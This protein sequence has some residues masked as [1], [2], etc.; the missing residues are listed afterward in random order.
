MHDPSASQ[1]GPHS[2][3]SEP[4]PLQN[5]EVEKLAH[6]LL[7][8]A[9]R[10]ERRYTLAIAG[11]PGSGKSTL[12]QSLVECVNARKGDGFAVVVAMDGFHLANAVLDSLGLRGVKGSPPT[13]DAAGLCDLLQTLRELPRRSTWI[14]V[15]C[16]RLHEPVAEGVE[17]GASCRLVVAEGQYLL[18]DRPPWSELADYFDAAW[19]LDIDR[20]TSLAGV[21]ERHMRGGNGPEQARRR[22]DEN[23]RPNAL[24]I[25]PTR[26]RAQ[27]VI[28]ARV[29]RGQNQ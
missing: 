3:P 1:P 15:Y 23:D 5:S 13:Y 22:I 28:D 7:C 17:A 21:A 18:L 29:L 4:Q 2:V 25:E 6:E 9:E 16:R 10:S 12:A 27:K 24:L 20:E 8:E 14:P 19:Y 26:R 11:I